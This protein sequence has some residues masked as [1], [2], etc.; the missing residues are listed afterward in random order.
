MT[1]FPA[2]VM[3]NHSR[4]IEGGD[5]ILFVASEM[6]IWGQAEDATATLAVLDVA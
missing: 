4:W 6:M 2:R 1:T 5:R 3:R